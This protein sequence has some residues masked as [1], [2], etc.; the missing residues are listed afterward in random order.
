MAPRKPVEIAN[1]HVRM[2]ESLRRRLERA[3][4]AHRISINKEVVVR[5]E[6]SFEQE[7]KRDFSYYAADI[8]TAVDRLGVL[9]IEAEHVAGICGAV[10]SGDL[11]RARDLVAVLR[12][13]KALADQRRAREMIGGTDER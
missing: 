2:R 3:A 5:L 10:E 8:G 13:S 1:L 4:E 11:D 7:A 6:S 12:K 9:L